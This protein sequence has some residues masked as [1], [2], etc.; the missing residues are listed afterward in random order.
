MA[1]GIHNYL[2]ANKNDTEDPKL[3]EFSERIVKSLIDIFLFRNFILFDNIFKPKENVIS[4]K[5]ILDSDLFYLSDENK[6]I[7]IDEF[8][9]RINKDDI[10]FDGN[11]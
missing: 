11:N 8:L 2:R 1:N 4:N 6:K 9:E 7:Y 3:Q 5:D 10:E